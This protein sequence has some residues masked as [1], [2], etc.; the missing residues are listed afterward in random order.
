MA[1]VEEASEEA[2]G[3]AVAAGASPDRVEIVE[4]EE[5]PLAYLTNPAV[6]IRAKAAGPLD[7]QG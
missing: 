3:R 6:R 4:L 7:V 1:A 5:I 2:R